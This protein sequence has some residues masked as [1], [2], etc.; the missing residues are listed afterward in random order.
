E[1]D[2]YIQR[3]SAESRQIRLDEIEE[4]Q[5]F[6]PEAIGTRLRALDQLADYADLLYQLATSDAPETAKA[7]A[8]DLGK[9]LDNLSSEV[10]KLSGANN[11]GFK[12]AV[13]KA[14]PI[15]GDVLKG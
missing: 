15:I 4:V 8:T 10:A 11:A 3:Q 14:F 6:T 2:R 5:A 1:R 7:R 9:A 12:A 13:G